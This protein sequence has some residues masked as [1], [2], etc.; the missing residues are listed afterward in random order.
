MLTVPG[1]GAGKG[2]VWALGR[3]RQ[4]REVDLTRGSP[5]VDK[6]SCLRRSRIAV[7]LRLAAIDICRSHITGGALSCRRSGAPP[8]R[9]EWRSAWGRTGSRVPQAGPRAACHWQSEKRCC[10]V[11]SHI[12]I[13]KIEKA[14]RFCAT[15][16]PLFAAAITRTVV[17][18]ASAV[19]PCSL[20]IGIAGPPAI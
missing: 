3:G 6:I 7:R 4:A 11:C 5:R 12:P 16:Q 2:T 14:P 8:G 15:A 10:H 9:I 17:Q 20:A 18:E 1:S 13:R 19:T